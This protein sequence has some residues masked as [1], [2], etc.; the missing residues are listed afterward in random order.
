MDPS[1]YGA[2]F[3]ALRTWFRLALAFVR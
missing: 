2:L 1:H 3:V